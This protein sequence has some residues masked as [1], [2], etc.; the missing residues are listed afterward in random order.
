MGSALIVLIITL[1]GGSQLLYAEETVDPPANDV[2]VLIDVS[3]SMKQNDPANL[4]IPAL[5]L[6]VNLLPSGSNAG[7]GLFAADAVELA[8]NARVG[9]KW[10]TNALN[11]AGK[12]HSRGL[13]TNIETALEYAI[14]NWTKP[15]N[16]TR[17]SVILL[18]DGVVDV[19]KDSAQSAASRKRIIQSLI[20][21]MQ[22]LSAQVHTIALSKN[23]D[24]ELLEKI[25]FDTGGWNESVHTAEQLQ[26][27]F[28]KMF[29]KAVSQDSVPLNDNKFNIDSSITEFS[30]LVFRKAGASAA[31]L[32]DPNGAE[33]SEEKIGENL[34]WY[35]ETG[36]DLVTV[37]NP[38]PG[39]WQLVADIDPD[40]QVMI[41][42]DLKL[43]LDELP[44]YVAENEALEISVAFTEQGE[45]ITRSDFLDL[46]SVDLQQTDTQG[47]KRD[48][49]L[50]QDKA[51]SGS[52]VQAVGET[53]SPGVQTFRI[54][55][56]GRTF[57]REI[58][59]TLEVVENPIKLKVSGDADAE[60]AQIMIDLLPDPEI[61]DQN[62]LK[63]SVTIGNA[64]G[65]SKDLVIEPDSG[66][67]RLV[68][69]VPPEGERVVVNFSV[70][71]KTLRG[72]AVAPKVRPVILDDKTIADLLSPPEDELDE[73][74]DE[75]SFVD[76]EAEAES[77]I[78]EQPDWVMTAVIAVV[79]N[80][81]LGVGGFFLYKRMKKKAAEQQ[82]KLIERL[83]T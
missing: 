26:R 32:I 36:Y 76:D 35:H 6:L 28:L 79:V 11:S 58:E 78:D 1:S 51:Q 43:S 61:I 30:L 63:V 80:L 68:L 39:E 57:Q 60:P 71:A 62:S 24:Q 72:N 73:I 56:N 29:N 44:N 52:Y 81:V 70:T 65:D 82:S 13:F 9:Q 19:S 38:V 46:V 33:L 53:L 23:A 75:D 15:K 64:A 40:N 2:R 27:I 66:S 22:Q 47:R 74:D 67:W 5:K 31:H 34:H 42:T 10:K 41:V 50:E 14:D 69:N 25:A 45:R 4:R 12:I 3:G 18:T 16:A 59:Q 54:V 8:P 17:R 7:I 77:E 55:A 83:A 21:R 48:W 49:H 20:P 37:K